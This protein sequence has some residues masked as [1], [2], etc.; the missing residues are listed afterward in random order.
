MKSADEIY[1]E[2]CSAYAE[3]TGAAVRDGCDMAVRLYAAAA[4]MESLYVYNDWVKK[5]CFPQ[6]A[7]GEYLDNHAAMRGLKRIEATA[8][9]GEIRFSTSSAVEVELNVPI[10][11]VCVTA[12]GKRFITT[13]SGTIAVGDT[14][15]ECKAIAMEKGTD[16]NVDADT[17]VF[18]QQVPVGISS[19]VNTSPFTGG[20]D[21]EDDESLRERILAAYRSLPNGANSAY[22]EKLALSVTGVEAVKV[23]PKKRGIGTVDVIITGLEGIPDSTLKNNVLSVINESR[24]ICVDVQVL[25]PDEVT[26][27]VEISIDIDGGYDFTTVSNNVKVAIENYFNGKLLGCDVLRV[28]LGDIIYGVEGVHN[29]TISSPTSDT[30]VQADELPSLGTLTVNALN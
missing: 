14:S 6:T 22:Y 16:G 11:T 3:L 27:N 4:Q 9:E 5:Q 25:G 21:G 1:Q 13:E 10:D 2:M 28:K 17:I 19:C 15:C 23:I 24:E 12:S 20:I 8:S 30:E 18:M 7:D 26:V 29:Y